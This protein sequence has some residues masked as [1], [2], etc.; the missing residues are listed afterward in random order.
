ML[1]KCI[2]SIDCVFVKDY[3]YVVDIEDSYLYYIDTFWVKKD[4]FITIST[5]REEKLKKLGII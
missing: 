5:I 1:V 4:N 3:I 2:K